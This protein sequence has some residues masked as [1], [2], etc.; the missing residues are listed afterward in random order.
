MINAGTFLRAASPVCARMNMMVINQVDGVRRIFSVIGLALGVG[1]LSTPTFAAKTYTLRWAHCLPQGEF[2]EVEEEFVKRV[3]ERTKG[4]V[5]FRIAYS[6]ALG[7]G[8]EVL[9]LVSRG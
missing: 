5:R 3:E 4:A 1:L 8:S 9:Q 6:S 7:G 2:L